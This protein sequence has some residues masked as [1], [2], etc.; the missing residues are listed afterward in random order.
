MK[1]SSF[2]AL[3]IVIVVAAAAVAYMAMGAKT[4]KYAAVA[5]STGDVYFGQLS[6][7][8]SPRLENPWVLQRTVD[9]NNN[10]QLVIVPFKNAIWGPSNTLNINPKD[11]VFWTPLSENSQ[12]ATLMANP[13]KAAQQQAPAPQAPAPQVAP[14]QEKT[15]N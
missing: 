7:F 9:A 11:I 14:Q 5:L 6:L 10:S 3:I 15:K 4:G 2:I 8:P 13:E 1:K 12:A